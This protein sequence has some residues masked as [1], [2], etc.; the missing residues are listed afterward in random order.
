MKEPVGDTALGLQLPAAAVPLLV[1]T[2]PC[3]LA[4]AAMHVFTCVTTPASSVQEPS[5]N[6]ANVA[7]AA[8]PQ[9]T[10]SAAPQVQAEQPRVSVGFAGEK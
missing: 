7:I 9:L 6:V 2:T 4:G 8:P 5:L 1:E 10:P 3:A